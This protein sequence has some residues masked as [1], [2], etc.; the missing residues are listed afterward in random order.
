MLLLVPLVL[1]ALLILLLKLLL[2]SLWLT[3]MI[4]GLMKDYESKKQLASMFAR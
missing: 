3:L 4:E 1:L 2:R